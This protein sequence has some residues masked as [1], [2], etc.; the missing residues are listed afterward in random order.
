VGAGSGGVLLT[1]GGFAALSWAALAW[2]ARAIAVSVW[3]ARR[4]RPASA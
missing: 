4:M 2:M 3:V 1:A